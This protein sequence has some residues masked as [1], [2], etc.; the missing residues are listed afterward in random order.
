MNQ[1]LSTSNLD[2]KAEEDEK[3]AEDDN[4]EAWASDSE[5]SFDNHRKSRSRAPKMKEQG[6]GRTH[7]HHV[8]HHHHHQHRHSLGSIR[9]TAS[10]RSS[11][12]SA[13]SPVPEDPHQPTKPRTIRISTGSRTYAEPDLE[14]P[15]HSPSHRHQRVLSSSLSASPLSS[16]SPLK[17]RPHT[18][19]GPSAS[20]FPRVPTRPST[21]DGPGPLRHRDSRN[22]T[23]P[24]TADSAYSRRIE[25]L[26]ALHS[27]PPTRDS[28]PS[29]SIRFKD[30]LLGG[31]GGRLTLT[32]PDEEGAIAGSSTGGG[33]GK[34][35]RTSTIQ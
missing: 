22:S 9:R 32:P 3:I 8:H 14:S 13:P 27:A 2:R 1:L 35:S 25:H 4:D 31:T 34:F 19:D 10:R 5:P 16:S 26:R 30:D 12:R 18:A 7:V 29:R 33:T 24:G 15:K 17:T 23:R 6:S 20:T 28:S 11:I 21:A